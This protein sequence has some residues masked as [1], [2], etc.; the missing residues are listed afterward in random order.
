MH[1]RCAVY[2]RERGWGWN[3]EALIWVKGGERVALHQAVQIEYTKHTPA[4]RK[5]ASA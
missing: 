2:L 3:S 5:D 1:N 4:P